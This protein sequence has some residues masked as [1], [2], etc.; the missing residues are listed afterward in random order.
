MAIIMS[1]NKLYI[2][3]ALLMLFKILSQIKKIEKNKLNQFDKI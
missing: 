3:I 1:W 2:L